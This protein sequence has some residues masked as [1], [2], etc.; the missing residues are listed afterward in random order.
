ML[1]PVQ[2]TLPLLL[3]AASLTILALLLPML[4]LA[5]LQLRQDL[6][7][8]AAALDGSLRRLWRR[9]TPTR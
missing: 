4:P 2:L 8:L 1:E 5:L 9:I 7:A 6:Q 3:L